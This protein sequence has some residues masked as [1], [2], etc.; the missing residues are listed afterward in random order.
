MSTFE[1]KSAHQNSQKSLLKPTES[2]AAKIKSGILS[3]G[4]PT[5]KEN[6]LCN[7]TV[8]KNLPETGT[9]LNKNLGLKKV[10]ERAQR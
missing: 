8:R 9:T 4:K 7:R 2:Q 1:A 6:T 3:A 5:D 10:K